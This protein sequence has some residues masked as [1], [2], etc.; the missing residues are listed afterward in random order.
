M[1]LFWLVFGR[2]ADVI[3]IITVVLSAFTAWRLY[4]QNQQ[5]KQ[6]AGR[7][8][9]IQN[10]AQRVQFNQGVQTIAPVALAVSLLEKNSSIKTAVETY[11]RTVKMTMPVEEVTLDGIQGVADLEKFVNALREKHRMIDSLG[12]TELHVFYAGPVQ[13]AAILGAMFDNWIPVKLY[14]KSNAGGALYEYWMPLIDR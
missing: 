11:L 8:P 9:P 1:D 10:F 7:T 13:G 4:R 12:Y 2:V 5:L 14:Q 6:L 3:G